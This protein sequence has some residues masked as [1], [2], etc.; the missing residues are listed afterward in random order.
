MAYT[1]KT[2]QS[3]ELITTNAMNNIETGIQEALAQTTTIEQTK[4]DAISQ[5]QTIRQSILEDMQDTRNELTAFKG[6]VEEQTSEQL[7]TQSNQILQLF[8]R[9]LGAEYYNINSMNWTLPTGSKNVNARI[10]ELYKEIFGTGQS[11]SNKSLSV[12]V[13]DLEDNLTSLEDSTSQ[14]KQEI[15]NRVK[16][17]LGATYYNIDEKNWTLGNKSSVDTRINEIHE[18][19]FGDSS[20]DEPSTSLIEQLSQ[21]NTAIFGSSE[22]GSANG[23]LIDKIQNMIGRS[24]DLEENET[25]DEETGEYSKSIMTLI[26]QLQGVLGIEG[27]S[28]EGTSSN[29]V[30]NV[31]QLIKDMY[32]EGNEPNDLLHSVSTLMTDFYLIKATG[33]NNEQIT[34]SASQ[35]IISLAS[36]I[37]TVKASNQSINEAFDDYKDTIQRSTQAYIAAELDDS[38]SEIN[39]LVLKRDI[40]DSTNDTRIPLPAGGG[41]GG[42]SVYEHTAKFI[43]VIEPENTTINVGDDCLITFTWQLYDDDQLVSNLAGNLALKINNVTYYS[44]V[45][46]S[47][48][49]V[50][51]NLGNYITAT[52]RNTVAIT[53]STNTAL[54]KT[55]YTSIIA[56]NAILSSIFDPI[57]VQMGSS[58]SFPYIAVIGSS[59]ISKRLFIL[60][61]GVEQT[62]T[63]NVTA[64]EQQNT[65][66]F[67]TPAAGEHLIQAYFTAKI[68]EDLTITSNILSYGVFCGLSNTTRITSNFINGTEIEQYNNLQINYR[69][70]TPNQEFSPVEI[71]INDSEIPAY[72]GNVNSEPKTW[73][74]PVY[75]SS[76]TTL[77][78]KIVSGSASK[79]LTAKVIS[80]GNIPDGAFDL[81]TSGLQV[82][83]TAN[84]RTNE[85]SNTSEWKNSSSEETAPDINVELNNFLFY[86]TVDGWQQDSDGAY[87]L[88][89]RNQANVVINYP[90]FNFSMSNN[91]LTSGLTFE[92][93]FRTADV[94]D[95][96]ALICQC[97]EGLELN[98]NSNNK[99]I[100]LTPQYAIFNNTKRLETQYKEEEK[101]T[102][103]FVINPGNLENKENRLIYIYMNG[104]LSAAIP[105]DMNSNLNF[106]D[107]NLNTSTGKII[108]GSPDCTLDIYSIKIYNRALPYQDII[109]NWI[110]GTPKFSDKIERYLRN[111]YP[112]QNGLT[113]ENFR[114]N[115]PTTPYMIITGDGPLDGA[116]PYMPQVKGS[117]NK[118]TV[119]VQYVD[120]VNP[121]NSFTAYSLYVS[122]DFTG[123]AEAQVQGTSSQLYYRKNYKLKFTS[124]TQD[125]ILHKKKLSDEDYDITYET[126]VDPETG[127]ET[128]QEVSRKLKPNVIKE[129]YKLSDTSY[130]TFTF[131]IK[132]DV[133]SS[134]SVNNTGL[135]QIYDSTIRHF[136]I[137]PPQHDDERIRQGVEG[138]P[139]VVWYINGQTNETILLGRYNFNNDK[140]TED[141]YGLKSD[142]DLD[143]E[144]AERDFNIENGIYDES[145]EVKNNLAGLQQ[146][147]VPGTPG[148]AEREQAWFKVNVK[149]TENADGTTSET[150]SYAWSDAFESR[151]PDQ[152]DEGLAVV[153]DS[154]TPEYNYMVKRLSGLREMVEWVNDTVVWT[155]E[156]RNSIT[157]ESAAAFKAG[158]GNYFNVQA[159]L[160]FYV[161]TELFL[162]VDNRAKNMFWTRYQY[163]EGKRPK[164]ADYPAKINVLGPDNHN[165]FGWFTFPYDFD[166]GIGT[167]NQ[168]KNVYDYHWESSDV[169]GPD[170]SDIFGGQ[171][172]KLWVALRQTHT[173]EL[174]NTYKTM[175][176]Y[177]NYTTVESLFSK[178]QSIW[179]ETITNED[180]IVKYIDWGAAEGYDMLL[181]LKDMQ[182]KWWL[183][184]RFKYFNSKYATER[185][186]DKIN[187][188]IH[189]NNARIPVQVYA[190]SY[191]SLTVGLDASTPQAN[192]R[193]LRGQT[194]YL[195]VGSEDAGAVDSSGIETS[196]SPASSLKSVMN[197][198]T[199]NLSS[200]NFSNALRLQS[201]QIG[202]YNKANPNTRFSNFIMDPK[203]DKGNS[204]TPLLRHL[205]LRNCSA[206]KNDLGLSTCL[207]LNRVYLAGTSLTNVSLPNGGVLQT[208]QYPE[209]I[210]S[211]IIQNQPYLKNLIIGHELPEDEI[212]I[213]E[214]GITETFKETDNNYSQISTIYLNNIGENINTLEIIRQIP[215]DSYVF[216]NNV[217]WQISGEDFSENIWPKINNMKGFEGTQISNEKLADIRGKLKLTSNLTGSLTLLEVANRFPFLSIVLIDAQ[218]EH[219]YYTVNFYNFTNE[220]IETQIVAEGQSAN[221]N[222][223]ALIASN[224]LIRIESDDGKTRQGFAQWDKSLINIKNNMSVY[225]VPITE[226][227]IDF[228]VDD[229]N[230]DLDIPAPF[231]VKGFF[232]LGSSVTLQ[233]VVNLYGQAL[234]SYT[235]NYNDY[236]PGFLVKEDDSQFDGLMPSTAPEDIIILKVAYNYVPHVYQI[237]ILNTDEN[238]EPDINNPIALLKRVVNTNPP[239]YEDNNDTSTRIGNSI[240]FNALKQYI[241]DPNIA[242]IG[243]NE[244]GTE[245]ENRR[246][247]FLNWS[248]FISDTGTSLAVTGDMDI[249]LLYYD[250]NDYF[251]N[252]FVNKL[253]NCNFE[254]IDG[255]TS[256]SYGAFTHNSNLERLDCY[257]IDAKDY[258]FS[259]FNTL[260]DKKRIFV[261]KEETADI[262]LGNYCFY[263]ITSSII[264]FKTTGQVTMGRSCFTGA[265]D[266]TLVL[267]NSQFAIRG[268][269][270]FN[271]FFSQSGTNQNRIFVTQSAKNEYSRGDNLIPSGLKGSYADTIQ[272]VSA[273]EGLPT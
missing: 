169:K 157:A 107:T 19:I 237:R 98:T 100:Y 239:V 10:T 132:A 120:P 233:S 90:L 200:A 192:I 5:M 165:Y 173:A 167:N 135:V 254:Q 114:N 104:V 23:S 7:E 73:S 21:L 270:D 57:P 210:Q 249:K 218:G 127:E 265:K 222:S 238:G 6:Q 190:D 255:V 154:G 166:T 60:I 261:F 176:N 99:Y 103:D 153:A 41:G 50:T 31:N 70:L 194:G 105:Y 224:K 134:E 24:L 242:M 129:G 220:L 201:L 193:V 81:V 125:E 206:L 216:M 85:S 84:Q 15:Y 2:W 219:P 199:F 51:L 147:E 140:G 149:T 225:P 215:N 34:Q 202:T 262:N 257:V 67:P 188:R 146:F 152:D 94:A 247:Q 181:G 246:Y 17:A 272:L 189:V 158:I 97:F 256:L 88:R 30:A 4:E 106:N 13:K 37:A 116:N 112:R 131:C 244:V 213:E 138:Y 273:W 108:L 25:A 61:D 271:D 150:K 123:K 267:E 234:P 82:Y 156:N 95:S 174:E 228:I 142:L 42:G 128:Q 22:G 170:G 16:T 240:N 27:G 11:T 53:V 29:L 229:Q 20:S 18:A 243:S 186:S 250:K 68:D 227:R 62:L 221:D 80:S 28:S 86:R 139:M 208:I 69:V 33:D 226:Y 162:M 198:S 172:S 1:P 209:T 93:D 248:P 72:S 91:V 171:H 124:F 214:I 119:D 55:L 45:I 39:Y 121:K 101:I 59:S 109:A 245:W 35:W 115:S 168:G 180:M 211:I 63:N 14:D 102:I 71:Y 58:I 89:L 160:F 26:R 191:V 205:D 32:G 197:L 252:Y 3:N 235:R 66:T 195:N 110:N 49:P 117:E 207:F 148:S 83:L 159:L 92:M 251:T 48:V 77:T 161:F 231:T 130:P 52:G 64:I 204:L 253:I 78:I 44:Q 47:G 12:R 143:K 9:A 40:S 137:T 177:I 264:I 74:Y 185:G 87:F 263:G 179:S 184:N 122:Q 38:D 126:V 223:E 36:A 96:G 217:N 8:Q 113:V 258:C 133:A 182:R 230:Y 212:A 266:C 268:N 43:N 196:I 141:V 260:K 232:K 136:V 145:W 111:N 269:A 76:D 187:M 259:N 155:D 46:S 54:S 164:K 118:K 65:V 175:Y 183:Y 75:Q 144:I 79:I 151:F 203:D 56:Y 163:I 236:T 241:E 178:N